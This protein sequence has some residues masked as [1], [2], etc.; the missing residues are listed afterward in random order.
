MRLA[1]LRLLFI[2]LFGMDVVKGRS[3]TGFAIVGHV[4]VRN[5][6]ERDG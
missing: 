3:L 5:M 4:G 1:C 6:E 2:Q